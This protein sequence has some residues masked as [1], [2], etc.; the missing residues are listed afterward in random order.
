MT[1][2][3]LRK[4]FGRCAEDAQFRNWSKGEAPGMRFVYA[5][6]YGT[7]WKFTPKEWWQCV[8]RAIRNRGSHDFLLSKALRGRPRHIIK[9]EDNKFYSSDLAMRCVNPLDWTLQD[10]TNELIPGGRPPVVLQNGPAILTKPDEL[11][12]NRP[13]LQRMPPRAAGSI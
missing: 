13:D 7:I 11:S 3:Q 6:E 5:C 4:L 1:S 9:G 10:W 8:T 12:G 2:V